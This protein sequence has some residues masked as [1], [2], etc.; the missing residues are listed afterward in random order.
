MANGPLFHGTSYRHI[1]GKRACF[2]ALSKPC[3]AVSTLEAMAYNVTAYDCVVC[4]AMD[5]KVQSGW[6]VALFRVNGGKVEKTNRRGM[7]ENR[8]GGKNAVGI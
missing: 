1:G 8:R 3:A 2:F 7:S 4:A 6:H 5:A